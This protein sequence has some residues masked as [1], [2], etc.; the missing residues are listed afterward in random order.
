MLHRLAFRERPDPGE[1]WI[2]VSQWSFWFP[3]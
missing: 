1:S 2:Y 3:Y